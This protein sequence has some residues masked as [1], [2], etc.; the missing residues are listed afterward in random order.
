MLSDLPSGVT[1]EELK[2]QMALHY[3]QA[4][5]INVLR[6]DGQVMGG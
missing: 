3:G 5:T 6:D 2:A 1:L 4:M